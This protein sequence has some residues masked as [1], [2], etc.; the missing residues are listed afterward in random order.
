MPKEVLERDGDEVNFMHRT[1]STDFGVVLQGRIWLV[2]DG[3]VGGEREMEVREGDV[4]VQRGTN[5]VGVSC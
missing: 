4:V 2:M 1:Q 3:G 5:H